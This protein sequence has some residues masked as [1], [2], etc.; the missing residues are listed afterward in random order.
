MRFVSAQFEAFLNQE[1]WH[2][3]ATHANHMAKYLEKKVQRLSGVEIAFPVQANGVFA[4]LSKEVVSKLQ[5]EF[6]FY[7]WQSG[8]DKDLVRWMMSFDT[9]IEDIDQFC[10]LLKKHLS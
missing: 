3:H 9:T 4:W 7:V 8:K 5:A 6:P 10:Q 2:K 1:L